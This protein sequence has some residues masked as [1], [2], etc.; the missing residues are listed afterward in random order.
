MSTATPTYYVAY[1][2]GK[3]R[4]ERVLHIDRWCPA[5]HP[6]IGSM[7]DADV[8]VAGPA[9]ISGRRLCKDCLKR[10]AG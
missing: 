3:W 6:G 2:R 8:K 10:H 7:S 5:G 9:E 4:P 1:L